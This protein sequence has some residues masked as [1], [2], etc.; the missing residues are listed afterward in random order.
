MTHR[1]Y[2]I[3][4]HRCGAT[5]KRSTSKP[6]KVMFSKLIPPLTNWAT[7]TIGLLCGVLITCIVIFSF[8]TR[9]GELNIPNKVKTKTLAHNAVNDPA[10]DT[11]E[12]SVT[13]KQSTPEPRFDFYA[14]LSGDSHSYDKHKN[15]GSKTLDLK[16]PPTPIGKYLVQAGSFKRRADADALKARLTLNGLQAQIE[17]VKLNEDEYW[18]RVLLGPFPSEVIAAE[19]RLLLK[20]LEVDAILVLKSE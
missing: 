4:T 8:T 19:Q 17:L 16:S 9:N 18:H 20:T 14:E 1:L 7:F 3:P 13:A 6:R 5:K 11:N 12:D 10:A 2:Y 15:N